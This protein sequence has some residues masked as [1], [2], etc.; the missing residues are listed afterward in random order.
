MSLD[1]GQQLGN[2]RI[3]G[4][5]GAGGMGE[6]YRA[7]DPRLDREVA[8]KVLP[9]AMAGDPE[10]VARFQR[11]AKLLASLNHSNIAAVH[12][13]EEAEG[14]RF[15]VLEL[16]EGP[17]LSERIEAGPLM[18][19]E[20]L[21]IARQIAEALESAHEKGIV[22]R[23]LKP[24]NVKLT[25]E[26]KVKVLDFG[27]AKALAEDDEPVDPNSS[28]TITEHFTQ[29]GMILGTAAYMSPEQARGRPID[30][31]T[32]IWAFGC[33]LYECLTG[34]SIFAGETVTD[35]VGAVLHKQPDWNK[36]PANTPPTVQLLLRRCLAKD[37]KRRLRDIGDVRIEL[38]AS[39]ADP[40]SS[41]LGLANQAIREP[42]RRPRY[43]L[44]TLV[45]VF[46]MG[47]V[48]ATVIW[49]SLPQH[50]GREAEVQRFTITL[51]QRNSELPG[52]T[53]NFDVSA[54]GTLLAYRTTGP[55]GEIFLRHIN[56]PTP[57]LLPGTKGSLLP[58][59]SPDAQWVA[60]YDGQ[61]GSLRKVSVRGGPPTTLCALSWVIGL[62]W[63]SDGDLIA[64]QGNKV[65]RVNAN[66]GEPTE[67]VVFDDDSQLSAVSTC[68][69]PDGSTI[70][71]STRAG[72]SRMHSIKLH[73]EATGETK[74]LVDNATFPIYAHSGHLLFV[75]ESTL[76]AVPFDVHDL[77]IKGPA[78]PLVEDVLV[79]WNGP[80]VGITATGH[81]FF[82]TGGAAT[83]DD[84][85]L[86]RIDKTGKVDSLSE[87]KGNY[88]SPDLSPDGKRVAIGIEDSEATEQTSTVWILDLEQDVLSIL[89]TEP[90]EHFSPVW[91][92]DG[93][94]V[95]YHTRHTDN[96]GEAAAGS[97]LYRRRSDRSGEAELVYSQ[98]ID[99][100]LQ[101]IHPD[102]RQLMVVEWRAGESDTGTTDISVIHLEGDPKRTAWLE[103][104]YREHSPVISPDGKSVAFVSTETGANE[105]YIRPF[106]GSGGAQQVS[107]EGGFRPFWSRDGSTLYY[108]A[109][110]SS[111]VMAATLARPEQASE[112]A[113][114]QELMI[115][116]REKVFDRPSGLGLNL[117]ILPDGEGFWGLQFG[118]ADDDSLAADDPGLIH[119]M[120][121]AH[122]KLRQI[123]P[124]S[125]SAG[126]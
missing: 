104:R 17:T 35:S 107:R 111:A 101:C 70:L 80:H 113:S 44:A 84:R 27:L 23:D 82:R 65:L 4:R 75:R 114:S 83:I 89:S 50:T 45:A 118:N 25:T 72:S 92:P 60:Y 59:I 9:D 32:D 100:T 49:Q 40:T 28:P 73:S 125:E 61:Q 21:D 120:L 24:A 106:D 81:L 38:E 77:S 58:V 97:K 79:G 88:R 52:N 87:R 39:I 57:M 116:S 1:N 74:D 15:L 78:V 43:W 71:I 20:S 2:Y 13:F 3:V 30:K 102:G 121:N 123:A 66:G 95:Y 46:A 6:V 103:T 117:S 67:V 47:A 56:Q 36:L 11:E 64:C 34:I 115:T 105:V 86:I 53:R 33:V 29:P 94:W 54:D 112:D 110:R 126:R 63:A 26:G 41:V 12:G 16:V 96:D 14:K 7:V 99:G 85:R 93:E 19:E 68:I 91:S 62:H 8:I 48:L 124:V 119:V 22:H 31:R 109:Y 55:A 108:V 69:L 42:R 76:M 90:G 18:V 10:R 122:E 37:R 5:L 51:P 98:A